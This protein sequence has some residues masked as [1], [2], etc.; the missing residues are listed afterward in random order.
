MASEASNSGIDICSAALVLVGADPITSFDD[1]TSES[2]IANQLYEDVARTSLCN[3]RWRFATAQLELNR[4]VDVPT[5]RFDT[6][7][8]LPGDFL[9]VHAV[10]VRD[11]QIEYS[12]YG[13]K[14]YSDA[15]ENDALILDYTYR[16][17]EVDWPSY[18]SLA[19]TY[20]M[21]SV[22]ASSLVRDR[23]L[24]GLMENKAD[25]LYRVARTTDSQQQTTRKMVTS[26]FITERRS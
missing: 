5:G 17:S 23:N 26:R 4:L 22:F 20:Q 3:T 1:N 18:F 9:L 7:H 11:L 8:Q 6:A 25:A 19:V 14:I 13:D 24:T 15:T 12:L 2:L 21:A 10:T 16:A